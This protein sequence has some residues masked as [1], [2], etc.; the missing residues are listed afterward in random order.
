MLLQLMVAVLPLRSCMAHHLEAPSLQAVVALLA[1]AAAFALEMPFLPT[2]SA[3]CLSC[4][5]RHIV[6]SSTVVLII[7]LETSRC[8]CLKKISC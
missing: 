6:V 1:V 7:V 8:M 4:Y 2:T 3:K 5:G